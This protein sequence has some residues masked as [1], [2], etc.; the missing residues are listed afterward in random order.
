[1]NRIDL[2]TFTGAD[3]SIDPY[4]LLELSRKYPFIEWGILVSKSSEG[5]Y[6]F[7]SY[8]W[9]KRLQAYAAGGDMNLSM[10]MCGS[11]VRDFM[12]GN[13][14]I[15][16]DRP[17]ILDEFDRVQLNFHS[18]KHGYHE[19]FVEVMKLLPVQFIFQSD[20]VNEDLYNIAFNDI[21]LDVSVLF[22]TSGG[23]GRVPNEWPE[24]KL[25]HYCGYAGG[26]GPDNIETE[27]DRIYQKLLIGETSLFTNT[28][29]WIDMET[30]VRS[31]YDSLFDLEKVEQVC[32]IISARKNNV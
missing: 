1:M 20:G 12:K 25:G 14:S 30:N 8:E 15:L 22:D 6:R 16:C 23:I 32:K 28:S 19:N 24:Q 2:V 10:H 21:D 13:P 27:W 4:H 11:W 18:E 5:R 31:S 17:N 3:D 29:V 9:I 7:P 26:L